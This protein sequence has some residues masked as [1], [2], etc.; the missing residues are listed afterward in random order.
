[1]TA[2]VVVAGNLS[3]DDTVNPSGTVPLAPGGDALYASLGVAAWGLVPTLLT[4]VGD[5]YPAEHFARLRSSGI[6]TTAIRGVA[7]PTVHYRVTNFE[8]GRR[9]YRWISPS[10]RLAATSPGVDD[11]AALAGAAW[12]H[13]AAMP[14]ECQEVGVRAAR[15]AG[16]GY[17]LDPHEEYIRG[18]EPRLRAMIE[19]AVFVPSE[20]E[21]RLLYPDL[22][23]LPPLEMAEVASGRLE[24]W[25]PALIVVK[26]GALGSFIRWA[27]RTAHV[28]APGTPVVDTTGAGDAFCG[29]F[30]AGWL[31][32]GDPRVGAACG[33]IAAGECIGRFGAFNTGEEP[34][35]AER[36]RRAGAL[37]EDLPMPD[38]IDLD[39]DGSLDLLG[40][41]SPVARTPEYRIANPRIA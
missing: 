29:G 37:L 24:A 20:L 18:Y 26:L 19:G 7:G 11:Y 16:V 4:L 23:G 30:V 14:L 22:D 5:D 1:M 35:L 36:I 38:A 33:T 17:S 13:L 25:N 15:S 34:T 27:G 40:R 3:L 32:T 10:T 21:I 8:D 6:D 28:P 31:G 9:E 39:I 41:A 2:R 12:L